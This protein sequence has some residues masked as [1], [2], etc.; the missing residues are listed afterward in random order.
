MLTHL[1]RSWPLA[2]NRNWLYHQPQLGVLMKPVCFCNLSLSYLDDFSFLDVAMHLWPITIWNLHKVV[3][4]T[5]KF[6]S[7]DLTCHF[8][9]AI[10]ALTSLWYLMWRLCV[11]MCQKGVIHESPYAKYI[12]NSWS[13]NGAMAYACV[14]PRKMVYQQICVQMWM[15][16]L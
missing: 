16:I 6:S 15:S 14:R 3:S 13:D 2:W 5:V 4:A 12:W 11:M 8:A 1:L 9:S 7:I 10:G